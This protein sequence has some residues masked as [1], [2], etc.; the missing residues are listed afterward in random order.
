MSEPKWYSWFWDAKTFCQ[1]AGWGFGIAV[2]ALTVM[3]LFQKLGG[4][5]GQ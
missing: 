3:L 4:F 1:Y 2:G 5:C